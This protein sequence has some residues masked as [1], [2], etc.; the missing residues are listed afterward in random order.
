[1]IILSIV[2]LL[3]VVLCMQIN[4]CRNCKHFISTLY[5]GEYYIGD[6]HG[7]CIKFAKKHPLT[8]EFDYSPINEARN[9][10][11]LCGKTG[12]FFEECNKNEKSTVY[13]CEP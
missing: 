11:L 5:K 2:W 8:G 9:S 1:M 12:R 7:K 13:D 10:E 4:K 6:Y 3:P